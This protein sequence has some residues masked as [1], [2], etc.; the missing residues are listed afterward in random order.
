MMHDIFESFHVANPQ[1]RETLHQDF[2]KALNA[3]AAS[4]PV[5]TILALQHEYDPTWNFSLQQ[6]YYKV[7]HKARQQLGGE[8][9]PGLKTLKIAA[10]GSTT[11]TQLHWLLELNL[12]SS[13][14][15]TQTYEADYGVFRQQILDTSSGLYAFEP[16]MLFVLT[17]HRDVFTQP[18]TAWSASDA[19]MHVEQ[20]YASWLRLWETFNQKTGRTIIQ[21][22]FDVPDTRLFGNLEMRVPGSEGSFLQQLNLYM[23]ANLPE[24]VLLHDLEYLSAYH[25]KKHFNDP[26]FFHHSKQQCS[27]EVLPGYAASLAA[28]VRA[29]HG[30]IRKCLVLDLDNTLWGGIIG[31]DGINGIQI[32]EGTPGGEAYLSLQ[33]YARSLKDRGILLAVCS[34]NDAEIAREPFQSHPDM[35]LRL[36]DIACFVANWEPKPDNIRQI[37]Q[38]LNIGLDSLVFVDDNPAER[39]IVRQMLPEVAVPELPDDPAM[40]RRVLAEGNYFESITFSDEDRLRTRFYLDNQ[41]RE[42]FAHTATNLDDFLSKLGMVATICP[43]TEI[44]L[45]RITQLV[46]RSNQFNLTTRRYTRADLQALMNS[47]EYVTRSIRLSDTFGDNGLISVWIGKH[48][49]NKLLIDTWLMS[50]RVLSRGVEQHLRNHIVLYARERGLNCV[51]GFYIPTKKNKL[52]EAHYSKLGFSLISTH[53]DGT[54]E[55]ELLIDEHTPIL[56]TYI[57]DA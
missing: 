39:A 48:D 1:E 50:C 38:T 2:R 49:G 20:E 26:R 12:L 6:Q 23:A 52:V 18:D 13:G 54:T 22:N 9:P 42:D 40:Y 14:W 35:A 47:P 45:D 4:D 55:W 11:L 19:Q 21:N 30:I 46:A 24:Y 17:G 10:V 31:D 34:K 53:E 44:D 3:R 28:I 56:P 27:F 7:F 36:D 29:Q 33:R 41:K 32:G 15:L 51:K 5:G 25:G 57:K 8:I 16:Q 43:F 37:A